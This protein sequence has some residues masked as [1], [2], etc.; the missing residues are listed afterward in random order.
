MKRNESFTDLKRLNSK[1]FKVGW[2]GLSSD[3]HTGVVLVMDRVMDT[4]INQEN[5]PRNNHDG[6]KVSKRTNYLEWDE[7]FMAVAF[8]SAQR[9]KDPRSQVIE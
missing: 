8:L 7:Y 1:Y 4:H 5:I 6:M 3:N 9:S 2:A